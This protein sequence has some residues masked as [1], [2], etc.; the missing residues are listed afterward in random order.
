YE[1]DPNGIS[2]G[3]RKTQLQSRLKLQ[4]K[5]FDGSP[6]AIAGIARTVGLLAMPYE[7]A[8]KIKAKLRKGK[9]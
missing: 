4:R 6:A 9:T 2:L 3:K 7:L 5:Y 8:F 1:L